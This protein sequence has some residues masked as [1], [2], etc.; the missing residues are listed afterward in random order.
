MPVPRPLRCALAGT[1]R[2]AFDANSTRRSMTS[3]TNHPRR[4]GVITRRDSSQH[5]G[6]NGLLLVSRAALVKR[7]VQI[8][9]NCLVFFSTL[10]LSYWN[11]TESPKQPL[12]KSQ[13]RRPSAVNIGI[14]LFGLLLAC[15]SLTAIRHL[16][17]RE[18]SC[19]SLG[20]VSR[21]FDRHDRA[22]LALAFASHCFL[23]TIGG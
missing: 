7:C 23:H 4:G 19:F 13:L 18:G 16:P 5:Q 11:D 9:S 15:F 2:K 10:P 21:C 3:T 12:P 8:H 6:R 1:D 22:S 17:L 20:D 14:R